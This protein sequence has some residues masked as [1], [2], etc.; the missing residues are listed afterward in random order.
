M[1]H[2]FSPPLLFIQIALSQKIDTNALERDRDMQNSALMK[3]RFIFVYSIMRFICQKSPTGK[4]KEA[5][6]Y[7]EY[8]SNSWRMVREKSPQEYGNKMGLF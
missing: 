6:D 4:R 5:S 7:R 3:K 8:F 2:P 1:I